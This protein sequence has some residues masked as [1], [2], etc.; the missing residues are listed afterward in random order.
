MSRIFL[1]PGLK[2]AV[3]TALGLSLLLR[4]NH[5]P[6]LLLAGAAAIASKFF[7]KIDAKHAFNPA[8]FGIMTALILSRDAWVSPGQWGN[9]PWLAALFLGAGGLILGKVGRWETTAV[10]LGS[11]GAL[12]WARTLWLGWPGAIAWRHLESGSL[13]VFA[14]FMISD[15]RS[16]PDHPWGR[17]LWALTLA[18]LT[19][20][21]R[22]GAHLSAAPF[23][24]LFLC[25]PLTWAL[26]LGLPAPRFVW[27]KS[28]S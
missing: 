6:T 11:Y 2:S 25:S 27:G 21:L 26:D 13:L 4:A 18:S 7:L 3:I 23:W 19:F 12:E 9:A 14:F 28:A 24:A 16:T 22:Y 1:A 5:W 20:T 10:F 17:A 8:N 15:P